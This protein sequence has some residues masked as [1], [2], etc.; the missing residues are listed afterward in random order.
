[1]DPTTIS[2]AALVVATLAF[3]FGSGAPLLLLKKW[4]AIRARHAEV[5]TEYQEYLY[6]ASVFLEGLPHFVR[7]TWNWGPSVPNY[8]AGGSFPPDTP[9]VRQ[10]MPEVCGV[11]DDALRQYSL[12][13]S[14]RG[15]AYP[16]LEQ[17][18]SELREISA[19][20]WTGVEH[21]AKKRWPLQWRAR[22]AALRQLRIPEAEYDRI[23]RL[24][25]ER[26]GHG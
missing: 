8:C 23:R 21:F 15:Q 7:C 25:S 22:I 3:V 9:T 14:S 18:L 16:S 5:E 1:M 17:A 10:N 4:R 19:R 6:H 24:R 26:D 20:Y 11:V 2:I 13:S 12:H